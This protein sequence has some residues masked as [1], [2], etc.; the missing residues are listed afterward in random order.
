MVAALVLVVT[1]GSGC[2][3][4]KETREGAKQLREEL[5]TP[6]WASSVDVESGLDGSFGDTVQVTVEVDHAEAGDITDFVVALPG[7]AE[8]T[9]LD[10]ATLGLQFVSASRS[11]LDV[12]WTAE[13]VPEEVTRGVEEWFSISAQL[14]PS[15]SASLQS[16]GGASYA[17]D[18][19]D[20]KPD[21]IDAAYGFLVA[22]AEPDT[23]AAVIAKVG[24]LSLELAVSAPLTQ[25]ELDTWD[26][27]L[28]SVGKLPADLP[29]SRLTLRFLDRTVADLVITAPDDTTDDTF[30]IAAYGD[31]LWPAV[32]PQLKA[33]AS[34]PDAWTY[35][36]A[37]SPT[38]APDQ[39]NLFIS[40]LSDQEPIDNGDESTRWSQAAKDY[41]DGLSG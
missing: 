4:S 34:L 31:R 36:A 40:L 10:N 30:T 20:G 37:W 11:T 22:T 12:Y 24:D 23:S 33:L 3:A 41:V 17:V 38:Y 7:L 6:S 16:D 28:D 5:G 13:V 35:G 29:A 2:L 18:L 25:E 8:E 26:A 9:G 39:D 15:A 21:A 19:G 14:G 32:R 1:L 27:L